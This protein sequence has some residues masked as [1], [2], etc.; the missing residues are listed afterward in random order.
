MLVLLCCSDGVLVLLWCAAGVQVFLC[1]ATGVL[2]L[3]FYDAGVLVLLFCGDRVLVLLCCGAEVLV[4]QCLVTLTKTGAKGLVFFI[5][6]IIVLSKQPLK[7]RLIKIRSSFQIT[8]FTLLIQ[9][10]L[11]IPLL[12]WQWSRTVCLKIKTIV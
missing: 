10:M 1:C 7:A 12:S 3:L 5:N 11:Q 6:N 9:C 8:A 2:V 4:L